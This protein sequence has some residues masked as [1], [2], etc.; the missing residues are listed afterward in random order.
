MDPLFCSVIDV[1]RRGIAG[2]AQAEQ[3]I[4]LLLINRRTGEVIKHLVGHVDDVITNKGGTFAS[5]IL[6][7]LQAAFPLQRSPTVVTVLRQP[8]EDALEI[9]LAVTQ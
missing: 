5:P 8:G 4:D 7:M 6:W 3:G 9:H 2:S 1:L